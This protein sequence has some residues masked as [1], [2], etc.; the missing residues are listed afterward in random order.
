[1]AFDAAYIRS[2]LRTIPDFPQKGIQFIDIFPLFQ[3]PAAVKMVIDHIVGHVKSSIS[4]SID[5]VVGLDARGFLF[6]PLVAQQLGV[7]FAPVRKQGKLPGNTV[8]VSYAKEYG[9]DIF[10]MEAD[11]IQAGHNVLIIDDLM[12]TGGSARAAGELVKKKGGRV[13]TY[14][15]LVEL[16]ELQG[17]DQLD[18]PVFSL[19]KY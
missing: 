9:E 19:L 17:V 10:E 3:S 7:A 12:A 11:S 1:M 5:A 13:C 8:Q 4:K 16:V 14:V 6:G 18:A 2:L 15:F